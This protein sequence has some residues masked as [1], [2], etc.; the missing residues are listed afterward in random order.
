MTPVTTLSGFI[1]MLKLV[2]PEGLLRIYQHFGLEFAHV[3]LS[4]VT[5]RIE[6]IANPKTRRRSVSIYSGDSLSF[7]LPEIIAI[8]L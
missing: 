7:H 2:V 4:T 8:S 3:D 5:E 1:L 6:R